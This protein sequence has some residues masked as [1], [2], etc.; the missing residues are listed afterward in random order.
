MQIELA[1]FFFFFLTQNVRKIFNE[2]AVFK[3]ETFHVAAKNTFE[4][5]VV[6]DQHQR[7]NHLYVPAYLCH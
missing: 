3:M 6:R 4:L 2:S 5:K 7:L 1:E